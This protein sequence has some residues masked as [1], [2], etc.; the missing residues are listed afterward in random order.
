MIFSQF[1]KKIF[2]RLSQER[3]LHRGNRSELTEPESSFNYRW[4][5]PISYV[6]QANNYK[7]KWMTPENDLELRGYVGKDIWLDPESIVFA[8]FHYGSFQQ[9]SEVS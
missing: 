1:I 8:R 2:L 9:L 4:T 3:F 6:D 5:I 7:L